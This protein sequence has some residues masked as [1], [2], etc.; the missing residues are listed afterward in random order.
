M[1]HRGFITIF[2]GIALASI[3]SGM[4]YF[5]KDKSILCDLKEYEAKLEKAREVPRKLT[6]ENES[7]RKDLG[8]K[9][10]EIRE[11]KAEADAKLQKRVSQFLSKLQKSKEKRDKLKAKIDRLEDKLC[12]D[13]LQPIQLQLTNKEDQLNK[14]QTVL[15][16]C[17]LCTGD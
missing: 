10:E 5:L 11:L 2:A 16:S 15:K 17:W 8:K 4:V 9:D 1:G 6:K 14:L 12:D 3:I 7:L 13:V